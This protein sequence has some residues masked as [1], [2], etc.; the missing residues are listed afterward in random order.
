[1]AA[2]TCSSEIALD[3]AEVKERVDVVQLRPGLSPLVCNGMSYSVLFPA[4]P[5]QGIIS[6]T[7][8]K[9][10]HQHMEIP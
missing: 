2:A 5:G 7:A 4:Q 1:M 10:N 8:T 6:A 9:V 3:A